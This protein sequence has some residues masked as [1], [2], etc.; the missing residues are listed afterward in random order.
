MCR[1]GEEI[2]SSIRVPGQKG[3]RRFASLRFITRRT[4][5]NQIAFGVIAAF[6]ARLHVIERQLFR[7]KLAV[8]VNAAKRITLEN[9]IAAGVASGS[10]LGS[11]RYS[12]RAV[13]RLHFRFVDPRLGMLQQILLTRP[14]QRIERSETQREAAVAL[15]LRPRDQLEL[16][17]IKRAHFE[18][19]PWSGHMALPGGRRSDT[20]PD[21]RTTAYR[22]TDEEIGVPLARVG[23]YL[24]A[25][26]E[27]APATPRL[28]PLIIA[29]YVVAV[30]EATEAVA[31]SAEVDFAVW[32]PVPAL[33][34]P[35]AA[36]EILIHFEEGSRPYPSLRY[37]DHVI[38]GLTLRIL[39]QFFEVLDSSGL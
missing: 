29:P 30:P 33:R 17:L 11:T 28:P 36:G 23:S 3:P 4:T 25:L 21:L 1:I 15:L 34:E 39:S 16:L 20:D 27:V 24:G 14:P 19:D 2:G 5:R 37:G 6:H 18:R 22:E 9:A 35:G 38:W 10:H 7:R 8:A 12:Q 26:D 31:N 13:P 32:V